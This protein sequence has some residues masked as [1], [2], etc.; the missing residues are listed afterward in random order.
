LRALLT[1]AEVATH[2]KGEGQ[3]LGN[4]S[5]AANFR[6]FICHIDMGVKVM[7]E[8]RWRPGFTLIELLVVIAI[9]AILIGLL[10]P[11]VQKI[12]EAAARLQCTN[13]LKQIAL[14]SLVYEQVNKRLPPGV[15]G[16]TPQPN[17]QY[18]PNFWNYT[19][20]SNL[21]VI[22][23]YVEQDTLYKQFFKSQPW[24]WIDPTALGPNYYSWWN[25]GAAWN[26]AFYRIPGYICPSDNPY[27]RPNVFVLTDPE[28]ASPNSAYLQEWYFPGTDLG[29]TNYLGVGGR[30]GR[31][32]IQGFD[33]YEGVF[34]S[35]SR[36]TMG[37]IAS[38]DGA[39]TTLFY[40]EV[41]GDDQSFSYAWMSPGWLPV[42]YG[43]DP[44]NHYWWQFNSY[45]PGI[46]QFAMVDGSVHGV[47]TRGTTT[48]HLAA[49]QIASGYKD[50][51]PYNFDNLAE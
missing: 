49:L 3:R 28:Q 32:G 42:A 21:A 4:F 23:P 5:V 39:S 22:L 1:A 8:R 16:A 17:M 44:V 36:V 19:Y 48:G 43:L 14:G 46:V 31:V 9:I 29:R 50:G 13:N 11:A 10:L 25:D 6:F 38:R 33:Q 26:A 18:D 37:Q 35:Q 47:L 7:R 30:M 2:T 12:R 20:F 27:A 41:T 45:H 34:N 24:K 15:Y 51:V 40:G